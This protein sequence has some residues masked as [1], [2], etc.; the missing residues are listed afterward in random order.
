MKTLLVLTCAFAAY[1]AQA[2]QIITPAP[3]DVPVYSPSDY[4]WRGDV[5][6]SDAPLR[7][8]DTVTG[9]DA[10]VVEDG[11]LR[12]YNLSGETLKGELVCSSPY[13]SDQIAG[14]DG[15][16]NVVT[17]PPY[18]LLVFRATAAQATWRGAFRGK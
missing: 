5:I 18:A 11:Y 6:Y 13:A 12:L 8:I 4:T 15:K 14:L 9:V 2:I 3:G 16:K 17:V 10:R 7:K 1:F